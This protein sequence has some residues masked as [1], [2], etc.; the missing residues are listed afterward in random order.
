VGPFRRY[1]GGFENTAAGGIADT[2][3]FPLRQQFPKMGEVRLFIGGALF[4]GEDVTP[5][6]F[7]GVIG[8]VFPRIPVNHRPHPEFQHLP[9]QL[10]Y[11]S[12]T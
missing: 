5:Q 8:R 11:P 6:L 10:F 12:L 9:L 3:G 2:N 1:T 4:Q 7:V